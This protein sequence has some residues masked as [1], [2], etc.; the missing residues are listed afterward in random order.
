M[1]SPAA[2]APVPTTYLG[3][4]QNSCSL[5]AGPPWLR[6]RSEAGCSA[7]RSPLLLALWVPGVRAVV[8][9]LR[10]RAPVPLTQPS[11]EPP[12]RE[13]SSDDR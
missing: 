7:R 13:G 10:P 11:P 9:G 4:A 12:L 6:A 2:R 3:T 8:P 5:G 1:Q